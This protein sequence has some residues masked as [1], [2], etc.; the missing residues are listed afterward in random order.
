M[1]HQNVSQSVG[2]HQHLA[3]IQQVTVLQSRHG[4]LLSLMAKRLQAV[5]TSTGYSHS[6]SFVNQATA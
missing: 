4:H 6:Q 2:H 5:H 3:M 1:L